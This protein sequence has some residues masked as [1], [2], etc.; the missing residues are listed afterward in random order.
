LYTGVLVAAAITLSAKTR[1]VLYVRSR[2]AE[3][4]VMTM[5]QTQH[6]PF[7]AQRDYRLTTAFVK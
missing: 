1:K 7:Q 2:T 5:K 6:I 4:F 3:C